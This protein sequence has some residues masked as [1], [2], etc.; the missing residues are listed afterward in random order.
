[1]FVHTEACTLKVSVVSKLAITYMVV[2]A[3]FIFG[4]V[5]WEENLSGL[6]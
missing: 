2:S 3:L 6:P 5:S 4:G 1:M